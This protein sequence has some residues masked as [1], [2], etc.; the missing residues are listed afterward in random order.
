LYTNQELKKRKFN[1]FLCTYLSA[2]LAALT[3]GLFY[4]AGIHL[5]LEQAFSTCVLFLIPGVPLINAFS[6]LIEGQI[7]Y[8][9]E[10]GTT[11]LIHIFSIA[12]ALS[13][14]MLIYNINA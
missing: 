6:D 14:A 8:G 9:I 1:I 4:A 12:A 7:L 2:L 13:T 10:R 5:N 3:T 11:A